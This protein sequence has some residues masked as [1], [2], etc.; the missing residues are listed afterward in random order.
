MDGHRPRSFNNGEKESFWG[1]LAEA[2]GYTGF[3]EALALVNLLKIISIFLVIL[4]I[5]SIVCD[6][7]VYARKDSFSEEVLGLLP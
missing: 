6:V 7:Y 2:L 3:R 5:V 4:L 1:R